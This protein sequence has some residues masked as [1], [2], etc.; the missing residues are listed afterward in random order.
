MLSNIFLKESL[1]RYT[2]TTITKIPRPVFK[3]CFRRTVTLE[4]WLSTSKWDEETNKPPFDSPMHALHNHVFLVGPS[5]GVN[6]CG[7]YY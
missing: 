3:R 6:I 4:A 7:R 2:W 1:I 5:I